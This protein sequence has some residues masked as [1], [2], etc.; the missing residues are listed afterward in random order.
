MTDVL[1]NDIAYNAGRGVR[2]ENGILA[3]NGLVHDRI[4]GE[5]RRLY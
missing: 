3:T 1:G 4:V 2:H 5:F